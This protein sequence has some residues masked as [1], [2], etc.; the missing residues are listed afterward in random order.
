MDEKPRRQRLQFGLSWLIW[1]TALTALGV[2][3]IQMLPPIDS[4]IA[5]YVGLLVFPFLVLLAVDW[6]VERGFRRKQ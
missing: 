3:A 6:L 2:W 5:V 1:V 4:T